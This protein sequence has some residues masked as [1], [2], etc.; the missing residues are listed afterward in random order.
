MASFDSPKAVVYFADTMRANAGA[1]YLGLL[2]D[3]DST[4]GE[5][6]VVDRSWSGSWG[7]ATNTTVPSF[8]WVIEEAAAHGVRLYTVQAEGFVARAPMTR[9][10]TRTTARFGAASSSAMNQRFHDAESSLVS[11]A[12]ET[13]GQAFLKGASAAKIAEDIQSDMA[14]IYLI[15]FDP[16][17]FATD[18]PFPVRVRVNRPDVEARARGQLTIRSESARLTSRLMGAFAAPAEVRGSVQLIGSMIPTGFDDGKY[19]ALAQVIIPGSPQGQVDWDV[20]VS[21]VTRSRVR[22]TA[23]GRITVRGEG[24]PVVFESVVRLAPGPW[25]LTGVAHDSVTGEISAVRVEGE[26]PDPKD[27]ET[28]V[29]P[30]ALLQPVYAAFLRDGD[31]RRKGSLA[32]SADEPIRTDLPTALVGLVCRNR[33]KSEQLSVERRLVG[34]DFVEFPPIDLVANG[35]R[36]AVITDV[37]PAGTMTAGMFQYEVR[38]RNEDTDIASGLRELAALEPDE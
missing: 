26:W 21:V 13:G 22:E 27:E 24:V 14:C 32:R 9:L 12:M 30:I 37:I 33:S 1:H 35:N 16:S 34:E 7:S 5:Q 38:V 19:S 15:S 6:G 2:G 29:G 20:G 31:T 10:S 17:D 18:R 3:V 28:T 8:D 36:C 23:S 25:E 4:V 11:F